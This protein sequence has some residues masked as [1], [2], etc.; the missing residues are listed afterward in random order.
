VLPAEL[1]GIN[2]Q[3]FKQTL[4]KIMIQCEGYNW[5]EIFDFLSTIDVRQYVS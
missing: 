3:R 5:N 1:K 4:K 2:S